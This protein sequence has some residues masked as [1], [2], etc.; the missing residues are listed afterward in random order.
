[1]VG[2]RLTP[3]KRVDLAVE[4]C[5]RLNLP[6][7]VYGDGPDL[8]RLRRLAGP[9]VT[10]TGRVSDQTVATLFVNAE[11]FIFP[12]LDDF[13]VVGIEA[14]AAGTPIIAYHKGG[15]LDYVTEGQTGTFFTEQT[16]DSLCAA[17]QSFPSKRFNHTAIRSAAQAFAPERFAQKITAFIQRVVPRP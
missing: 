12:V 14:L 10:F 13:G 2:G 7:T 15:A 3:Y 4:A 17:L 1:M 5:T 9:S 16:V 6:L 11:A 8:P